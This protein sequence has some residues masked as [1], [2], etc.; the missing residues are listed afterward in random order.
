[1]KQGAYWVQ[2]HLA[3]TRSR[4][5]SIESTD[6]RPYRP[7]S[8][9]S[10]PVFSSAT[11]LKVVG[12]LAAFGIVALSVSA[13]V[14]SD[15][16]PAVVAD[17]LTETQ[18]ADGNDTVSLHAR[19]SEPSKPQPPINSTAQTKP[20][21][22]VTVDGAVIPEA[23]RGRWGTSAA[24]CADKDDYGPLVISTKGF[25]HYEVSA[26]VSRVIA[27]DAS[28]IRIEFTSVD[29]ASEER[30]GFSEEWGYDA[31]RRQLIAT[32][33]EGRKEVTSYRRC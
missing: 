26:N 27:I 17:S 22:P 2:R 32:T 10:D 5:K 24:N 4:D 19:T 9:G 12:F 31:S 13:L 23:F 20:A 1:M 7:R 28:T 15:D 30:Y 11:K 3:D 16:E 25:S 6:E 21:E 33:F 8:S 29:Q 14:A 18:V